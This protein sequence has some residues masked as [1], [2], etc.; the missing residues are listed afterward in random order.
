MSTAVLALPSAPRA[1]RQ[2]ALTAT[3]AADPKYVTAQ[4]RKMAGP[5]P[6][7]QMALVFE[8]LDLA[9]KVFPDEKRIEGVATLSLRTKTPISTLILDLFPKFAIAEVDIDGMR[10]APSTYSNPEGQLRIALAAPI[11]AATKFAAR[12]VYLAHPPL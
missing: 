7:E 2:V 9:L 3:D 11:A 1:Q 6:A 12:L 8:H 5:M 10:V 4:T